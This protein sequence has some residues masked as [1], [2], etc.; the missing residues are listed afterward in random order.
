[1]S[2]ISFVAAAALTVVLLWMWWAAPGKSK[3][4]IMDGRV[5]GRPNILVYMVDT[6]RARELGCHGAEVTRTPA[7]DAFAAESELFEHARTPSS[8]TRPTIA[9]LVTGVPPAVHGI[10]VREDVLVDAGSSLVRLPALL[11]QRG[12]Y[13]GAIVANPQVDPI[14]GFESGFDAFQGLYRERSDRRWP[15]SNELIA[16][17]PMVVEEVKRFIEN[18]PTDRPFFL[19]VL[20]I[21]PHAP[22][23][24]PA[25]YRAMYDPRTV[26]GKQRT[27]EDAWRIR[28]LMRAARTSPELLAAYRGEISYTD[29]AFGELI[30][31]M[32]EHAILDRTLVAFT[33]DHGEEFAEHGNKTHGKTLYEEVVNVPL[34]LRHPVYFQG[35]RRRSENVDLLD[36]SSTIAAVAGANAPDYWIGRNL[37][38]SLPERA[39]VATSQLDD[40]HHYSSVV[41]NDHKLIENEVT[42]SFELYNLALDPL[43]QRPLYGTGHDR[44]VNTLVTELR[45][46]REG[47]AALRDLMVRG[48]L[49]LGDDELP[50]D[51]RKRLESLGYIDSP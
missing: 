17:A 19:I 43:E 13:T 33:A 7:I 8:W 23:A 47:S 26:D 6:L 3:A 2:W 39:I 9:S 42:H 48:Q 35:G 14:F 28:S 5:V 50:E 18:A 25:P 22:Y 44:T 11:Q 30:D 10:Q 38:T 41:L 16:T 32:E 46:F 34:I 27:Q 45:R 12:Y 31:W 20:S 1:M 21:D 15:K 49:T 36:L 24:P 29:A 37:R 40:R 51:I 4:P